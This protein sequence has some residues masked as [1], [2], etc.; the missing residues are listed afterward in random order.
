VIE[1]PGT[2]AP[3][4]VRRVDSGGLGLAVH[5]WGDAQ[6]P[7]LLLAHGGFDFARTYDRFAPV[8]ADAG[9][10]VVAWDHRGH[11]DSD[12]AALYSWDADV[13]DAYAVL[14]STTDGALPLVGHSK[15][16]GLI[17]QLADA[18]PHRV[19]KIV[20][21]DGLP[22]EWPAPDVSDHERTRMM[23]ATIG[24]W[25]D[26]RRGPVTGERRPGTLDELAERRGRM[27]PRLPVEWLRYLVTVGARE[28][29][30][31]WRWKL[32][33]TMTFGGF[34]PW[35][36]VWSIER[37]PGLA[38]PMLGMLAV[39]QEAMGMGTTEAGIRPFM[40]PQSEL[41]VFDDTGHFIHIERPDEVAKLTLD[42]LGT[43]GAA[44]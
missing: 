17:L 31:G 40:P 35:R 14:C 10:R 26:K 44:S 16:G 4:R 32:D 6:A 15:G 13:R 7:P 30:D 43:P 12:R 11:G 21:I 9:W 37:L 5:E 8:L 19:T 22:S 18:A 33:P 23:A 39:V 24:E 28:S 34:G 25:L 29:D 2:R 36:S 20:N 41:V 38:V 3:D 1:F 27:N 42:F